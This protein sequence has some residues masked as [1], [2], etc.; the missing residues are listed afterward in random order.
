MNKM[1]KHPH[2][3]EYVAQLLRRTG[4]TKAELGR[5]LNTSRQ[6]VE[7]ILQARTMNSE[8]VWKISEIFGV[9]FF[10]LLSG[11]L[12]ISTPTHQ[13]TS[14]I[15]V[16]FANQSFRFFT[17]V[18][19]EWEQKSPLPLPASALGNPAQFSPRFAAYLQAEATAA[20]RSEY[21]GGQRRDYQATPIPGAQRSTDLLVALRTAVGASAIWIITNAQVLV[22]CPRAE[23]ALYPSAAV[24]A[25]PNHRTSR[26]A[27]AI[28]EPVFIAEVMAPSPAHDARLR[29][30][31]TLN[32]LV[33]YLRLDPDSA[34]GELMRRTPG[35]AWRISEVDFNA[36]P[37]HLFSIEA[38]LRLSG[39][40]GY[41]NPPP[42]AE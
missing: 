18:T 21:L 6:N 40:Q 12:M 5:R 41:Q 20:Q 33:E 27:E 16:A 39:A 8:R 11:E 7:L 32:S 38:I 4:M 24:I 30:Y 1:P 36:K 26:T 42:H 13:P 23:A 2:L 34:R 25:K 9:D 22:I 15:N 29:A 3:G 10:Q 19:P 31:S 14:V 17:R 35:A 37:V 28:S